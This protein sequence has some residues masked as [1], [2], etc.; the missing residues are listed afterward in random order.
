MSSTTSVSVFRRAATLNYA[1]H[2]FYVRRFPCYRVGSLC[3]TCSD[4]LR[5]ERVIYRVGPQTQ[6]RKEV[7]REPRKNCNCGVSFRA[8]FRRCDTS[9]P[10]RGCRYLSGSQTKTAKRNFC[11]RKEEA[12]IESVS[13]TERIMSQSFPMRSL[14]Q[15]NRTDSLQSSNASSTDFSDS[16]PHPLR[17]EKTPNN[18]AAENCCGRQRVS[19]W[20]LPAE[21]ATQPARHAP[22]PSAVSELESL[23]VYARLL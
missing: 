21:P 17:N 13:T 3:V 18:G 10:T 12:N 19:R 8:R 11:A 20:L 6:K 2:G 1:I 23:G 5:H 16:L 4:L 14:N 9:P 15:S 7:S 22:P